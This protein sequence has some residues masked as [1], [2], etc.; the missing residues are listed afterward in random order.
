MLVGRTTGWADVP[1]GTRASTYANP[2]YRAAAAAFADVTRRSI[3]SADPRNPG[4]Q[5]R[6]AIGIQ[7]VGI[8]EYSDLGTKV[9]Y[10]ISN[11]IAGAQSVGQALRTSQSFAE[12]VAEEYRKP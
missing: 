10:E 8:P 6:P 1:A 2:D 5:P 7:F 12:Q 11:A 3:S 9:S 4:L